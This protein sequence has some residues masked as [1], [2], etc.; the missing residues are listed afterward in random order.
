MTDDIKLLAEQA[1][2]ARSDH[3]RAGYDIN[4][5]EAKLAVAVL[6]LTEQHAQHQV[7]LQASADWVERV[8]AERDQLR[9]KVGWQAE[10]IEKLSVLAERFSLEKMT[11]SMEGSQLRAALKEAC[12]IGIYIATFLAGETSIDMEPS[13]ARLRKLAGE[14]E[15]ERR[16][17]PSQT[18]PEPV[19]IR[20]G[21][22]CRRFSLRAANGVVTCVKCGSTQP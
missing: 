4:N 7:D 17:S 10:A 19:C 13:C 16:A 1:L 14:P 2:A 12:D 6:R 5:R 20:L 18:L 8:E 21:C 15:L 11:I 3:Q 22:G 9:A